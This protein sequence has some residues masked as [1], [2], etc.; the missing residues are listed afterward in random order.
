MKIEI[1]KS[2]AKQP[3]RVNYIGENGENLA[4][5]ENLSSRADAIKNIRAM[6]KL[7]GQ[8][9]PGSEFFPVEIW[10]YTKSKEPIIYKENL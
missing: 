9:N 8:G 3:L 6:G 10:D 1:R 7:F 2:R 5:S 4:T